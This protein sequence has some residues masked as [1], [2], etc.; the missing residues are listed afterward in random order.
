MTNG[1]LPSSTGVSSE[2]SMDL[3]DV[4]ITAPG[5]AFDCRA[6]ARVLTV[7]TAFRVILSNASFVCCGSDD[8]GY[9]TMQNTTPFTDKRL[10]GFFLT[11]SFLSFFP[12]YFPREKVPF[13][14]T[15]HRVLL[16]PS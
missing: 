16:H 5:T 6:M 4:S 8:D 7:L 12:F 11:S 14:R 1:F 3:I 13:L 2:T 10:N 9:K 15:E